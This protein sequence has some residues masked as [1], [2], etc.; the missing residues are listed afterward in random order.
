MPS[1]DLG[2]KILSSK[3]LL[4]ISLVI[5][6][7]FSTNLVKAIIN[8]RDLAKDIKALQG[9]IDSL[10]TKNQELA[11][12]IEYFQSLDFV[13]RE[14]RTKLNLK[15]P[16]EKI[17]IITNKETATSNANVIPASSSSFITSEV[18]SLTNL[19]RWWNYFFKYY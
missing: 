17:I 15:K 1:K 18:K 10:E 4:I 16:G 19:E 7:F 11:G 13:E 9:E 3:L 6:I 2:R 8:R 12:L 5:L 14:A